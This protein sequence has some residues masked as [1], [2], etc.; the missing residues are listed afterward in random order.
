MQVEALNT[1]TCLT[2]GRQAAIRQFGWDEGG[3]YV[4]LRYCQPCDIFDWFAIPVETI[5]ESVIAQQNVEREAEPVRGGN[6]GYL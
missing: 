6:S 4:A 5:M 1:P 3:N 2:C